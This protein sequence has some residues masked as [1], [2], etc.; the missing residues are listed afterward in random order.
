M[1]VKVSNVKRQNVVESHDHPHHKRTLHIKEVQL[2]V[3]M[4]SL[5]FRVW[6]NRKCTIKRKSG[7]LFIYKFRKEYCHGHTTNAKVL[8][9]R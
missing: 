4:H 6:L 9:F 8:L 7:V 5:Y 2:L 3:F 1:D